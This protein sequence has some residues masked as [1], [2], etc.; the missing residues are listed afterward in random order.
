M[1]ILWSHRSAGGSTVQQAKPAVQIEDPADSKNKKITILLMDDQDD[2][3]SLVAEYF[4]FEGFRVIQATDGQDAL[5]KLAGE[6]VDIIISDTTNNIGMGGIEFAK[7]RPLEIPFILISSHF[8]D[9]LNESELN[10]SA[11]ISKGRSEVL[12]D[13][14]RNILRI[15]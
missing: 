3:R 1:Q 7:K 13:N 6:K 8:P 10:L 9:N 5:D 11:R 4:E 12:L 2:F 14:V 15:A